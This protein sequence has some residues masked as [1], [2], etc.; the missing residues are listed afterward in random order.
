MSDWLRCPNCF[1]DL[2]PH[3]ERVLGCPAGH[4][5]DLNRRGYASLLRGNTKLIGDSAAM[6]DARER[7]LA[8]GWYAPLLD[9]LTALVTTAAPRTVVDIG[10]GSGY[11]LGGILTGLARSRLE[12]SGLARSDS[13]AA[14]APPL[15][16]LAVD[17]SPV[18]VAR[19][20]RSAGTLARAWKPG[21][22]ALAVAGLVADVWSP[23]P[24]RDGAAEALINV[25]APRNPAEFHRILSPDGLLAVVVPHPTHLQELRT[26]GL[27]LGLHENKTEDLVASLSGRFTLESTQDIGSVLRLSQTDVL[28]L[29]GMGPSSH[30]PAA[31][32][33]AVGFPTDVTVAFRLL[34]FR[35][36]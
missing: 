15:S 4:R 26:A 14:T 3:D 32:D 20:V 6:L 24:I 29:L 5:F 1:Q 8:A 13:H 7:F 23:L 16:A 34:A 19:T 22:P 21:S 17:L 9:A 36:T 33:G 25:F 11:Y 30:H 27:A 31:A 2:V 35:R 18:A 10:C 28:A 12:Q